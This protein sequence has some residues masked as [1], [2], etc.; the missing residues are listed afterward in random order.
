MSTKPTIIYEVNLSVD[1]DIFAD[2][3][4]W[5]PTHVQEVLEHKAFDQA[6]IYI[7]QSENSRELLTIH[8]HVH[9]Q[10]DLDDYLENKSPLL[11]A[12]GLEKFGN[13]F[14]AHRRILTATA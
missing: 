8:Y 1:K 7:Q 12:E 13:A 14:T 9:N 11:R 5:L 6:Q 10:K 2:F 4:Q 3:Q